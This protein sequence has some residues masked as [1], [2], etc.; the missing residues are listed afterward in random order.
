MKKNRI[1]LKFIV[2]TG[3]LLCT[4]NVFSQDPN[5]HIYLCFGQ[6]NMEGKGNI[7]EQDKTVDS[8][9]QV[10]QSVDCS[11]LGRMK[12]KWRTA[13]PPLVRCNTGLT[14]ADYFGRTMV[15]ELPDSIRMV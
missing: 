9:F 12:G 13:A 3:L 5:F 7:E 11:D 10:M 6:S 14:P 15:A 4:L 2:F 8:R 1:K